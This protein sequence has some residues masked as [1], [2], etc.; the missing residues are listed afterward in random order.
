MVPGIIFWAKTIIA[1]RENNL[2]FHGLGVQSLPSQL[3]SSL[4]V[5]LQHNFFEMVAIIFYH[6]FENDSTEKQS[7]LTNWNNKLCN[8][9]FKVTTSYYSLMCYCFIRRFEVFVGL[10][11]WENEKVF[12]EL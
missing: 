10:V 7:C 2:N 1:L 9:K 3:F 6:Q 4:D 12:T 5:Y 8:I 11:F